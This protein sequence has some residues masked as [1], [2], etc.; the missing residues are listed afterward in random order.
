MTYNFLNYTLVEKLGLLEV[1]NSQTYMVSLIN[2]T[3]KDVWDKVV[4]GVMLEVQGH[5]RKLGFHVMHMYRA[6]VVLGHKWLHAFGSL[7]KYG[8]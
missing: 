7:F 5:N 3:D 1:P 4:M 6:S 2:G 8:Y